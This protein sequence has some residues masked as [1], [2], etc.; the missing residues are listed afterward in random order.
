MAKAAADITGATSGTTKEEMR[1][2]VSDLL[3]QNKDTDKI[4]SL[5]T[6][7]FTQREEIRTL[8][9]EIARLEKLVPVEGS[10]VLAGDDATEYQALKAI[11]LKAATIADKIKDRDK[12]ENDL[13]VAQRK[14]SVV[15]AA[16]AE[17][18]KESA[19][20]LLLKEE[21]GVPYLKEVE[22]E[23]P[24][25]SSKKV[26]VQRPFV[27]V[28]EGD[29]ETEKRLSDLFKPFLSSLM[30]SAEAGGAESNVGKG[31]EFVSQDVGGKSS[32]GNGTKDLAK[33]M[34]Q[35]TYASKRS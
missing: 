2:F 9:A 7:N 20:E 17:N 14:M 33:R 35:S 1:Q 21:H 24:E 23:D 4:F 19:L 8:K 32:R 11:G 3:G 30:E 16:K 22:E 26:K 34:L 5:T 18:W 29:A 15:S 13:K 25:D 31:T 6:D 12:L 28:K 10:V 27:K